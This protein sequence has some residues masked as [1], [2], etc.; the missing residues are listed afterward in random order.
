LKSEVATLLATLVSRLAEQFNENH[1]DTAS[2]IAGIRSLIETKFNNQQQV[3]PPS[4]VAQLATAP[5]MSN[6][7]H[8]PPDAGLIL[9][10]AELAA[11]RRALSWPG[12]EISGRYSR[13]F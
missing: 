13:Q 1:S 4:T 11:S 7:Q 9:S 8:T 5:L 6:S 10:L 2:E 3:T 12:G